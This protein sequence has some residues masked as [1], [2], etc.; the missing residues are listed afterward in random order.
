M[1]KVH[2]LHELT[3]NQLFNYSIK[4]RAQIG[5]VIRLSNILGLDSDLRRKDVRIVNPCPASC[6]AGAGTGGTIGRINTKSVI[7]LLFS[8]VNQYVKERRKLD[9][10]NHFPIPWERG[11][12]LDSA[13][14]LAAFPPANDKF[15]NTMIFC[16]FWIASQARNDG[17][18]HR[19]CEGASRL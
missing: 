5:K 13:S 6:S 2:E 8:R 1:L 4:R 11:F 15:C 14:F 10:S 3:R 7:Q 18:T 9:T 12:S 17:D 19:H 16:F